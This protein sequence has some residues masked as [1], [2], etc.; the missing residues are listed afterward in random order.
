MYPINEVT[1][2]NCLA[3]LLRGEVGSLPIVYLGL[4]LGAKSKST[5]IWDR[6]IEKCEKKLARWKF[7]Y[8]SLGGRLTLI[9][10]VL[11]SLTTYMMSLFPIT[12]RV[13]KRLDSIRREFLWQGNKEK[14]R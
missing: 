9:I 3:A 4:P 11:D 6:V 14:K 1:N 8:L 2:M 12:V 7:Q 10:S 13:I 5:E